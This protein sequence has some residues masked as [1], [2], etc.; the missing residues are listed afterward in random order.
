MALVPGTRLGHYEVVA[1][2]GAGGMS[3]V[4]RARDTRLGRDVALKLLP[5]AFSPDG[6][7]VA[8]SLDQ[9][10]RDEVHVTAFPDRGRRWQVSP[11]GG[12][13]P[14]WQR[15]GKRLHYRSPG[16]TFHAVEVDTRGE[17]IRIGETRS[18][19]RAARDSVYV[20]LSA[21]TLKEGTWDAECS[22]RSRSCGT[23]SAK[24]LLGSRSY[25]LHPLAP[26]KATVAVLQLDMGGARR[27]P[28]ESGVP[29][30]SSR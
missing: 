2:L 15:D 14:D 7:Y 4:N 10:G 16:G 22:S 13:A 17:E 21:V 27:S 3:E 20:Q 18:L 29:V 12:L 8:Y 6:R 28:A 11:E 26:L 1:P 5:P 30:A 19:F 24:G 25:A 9:S 23:S